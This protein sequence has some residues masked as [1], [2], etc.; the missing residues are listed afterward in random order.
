M[1]QKYENK[2]AAISLGWGFDYTITKNGNIVNVNAKPFGDYPE[3]LPRI[4]VKFKV[5]K[6]YNKV[7]GMDLEMAQAI[8]IQTSHQN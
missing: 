3:L 1:M 4:G 6:K 2:I 8:L 5:S 7:N